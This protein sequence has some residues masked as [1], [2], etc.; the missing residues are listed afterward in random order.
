MTSSATDRHA[1]TEWLATVAAPS[2]ANCFGP[3][4]R[5]PEP[6]ATTMAEVVMV[7]EARR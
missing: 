7:R 6:P 1:S 3:P 2:T 4:K 5:R